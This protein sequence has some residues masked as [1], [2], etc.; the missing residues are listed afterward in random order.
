MSEFRIATRYSKSLLDL[1][2]EQNLLEDVYKDMMLVYSTIKEVRGFRLLLKSPIVKDRLKGTIITKI[3][4]NRIQK[5]TLAFLQLVSK[6]SRASMLESIA[7]E[8]QHQY[9]IYKGMQE[10]SLTTSFEVDEE[11]RNEFKSI[12]KRL[13]NKTPLLEEKV[14][15]EIIGGFILEIGDRR[16]DA[17]IKTNL[18]KIEYELS[19]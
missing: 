6:K 16:I 9:L 8:F 17:S 3:F 10:V 19:S 11:L 4:T 13:T 14:S 12:V 5:L 1:S 18:E 15:E 2:K 7:R